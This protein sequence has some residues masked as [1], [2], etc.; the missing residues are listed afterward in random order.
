M[1]VCMLVVIHDR[2][3]LTRNVGFGLHILQYIS[4]VAAYLQEMGM[5][6]ATQEGTWINHLRR[7]VAI[8]IASLK[9]MEMTTS[10]YIHIWQSPLYICISQ[11]TCGWPPRFS[12]RWRYDYFLLTRYVNS[13]VHLRRD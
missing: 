3:D 8:I 7:D 9:D 10:A 12:K 5:A 2:V 13:N 11:R 6:M 4:M 1:Y